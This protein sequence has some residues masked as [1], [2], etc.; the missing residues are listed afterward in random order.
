M[1][2]IIISFVLLFTVSTVIGQS[3]G[4]DSM[5]FSANDQIA[6]FH[7]I[8]ELESLKKGE[9]VKLYQDRIKEI[10]IV[11]PLI[12][13]TNESGATL[14]DVGIKED[15]GNVKV[16]KK[17]NASIRESLEATTLAIEELIPYADTSKIIAT[18]LYYEEIIKKMRIGF[19]RTF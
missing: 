16:L 4:S 8:S 5:F 14:S 15:S 3:K 19:D 10:M 6:K 1:S 2:K 12:S 13:L 17:S 7:T 18:I 9:L 11:L